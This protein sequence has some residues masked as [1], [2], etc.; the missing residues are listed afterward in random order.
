[1]LDHDSLRIEHSTTCKWGLSRPAWQ[2]KL[3]QMNHAIVL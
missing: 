3:Q 1:M 2:R